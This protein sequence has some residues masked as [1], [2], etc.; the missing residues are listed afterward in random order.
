MQRAQLLTKMVRDRSIGR[1]VPA[2]SRTRGD[3]VSATREPYGVSRSRKHL[4]ETLVDS[5]GW[6]GHNRPLRVT[7]GLAAT[8]R[9]SPR[10]VVVAAAAFNGAR[11]IR[12]AAEL[13]GQTSEDHTELWRIL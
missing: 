13:T 5:C 10:M 1:L 3:V 12:V 11:G 7:S 4:L 6:L 2:N 8:P 9:E